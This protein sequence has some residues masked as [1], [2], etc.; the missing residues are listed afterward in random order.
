[1]CSKGQ[2]SQLSRIK[3]CVLVRFRYDWVCDPERIPG[4]KFRSELLCIWKMAC[5]SGQLQIVLCNI[6]KTASSYSH[7]FSPH[8]IFPSASSL[9]PLRC[10]LQSASQ[11]RLFIPSLPPGLFSPEHHFHLPQQLW[12]PVSSATHVLTLTEC[13]H[14][15]M[16]TRR[17]G[18]ASMYIC[19]LPGCNAQ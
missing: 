9:F 4:I 1:M 11:I 17:T 13:A 7:S 2:I 16:K 18:S 15:L 5:W 19:S 12:W 6:S 3:A 8:V 14:V 10:V